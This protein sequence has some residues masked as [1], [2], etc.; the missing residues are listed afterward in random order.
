MGLKG[1]LGSE[2]AGTLK[3][4]LNR[5]CTQQKLQTDEGKDFPNC[6]LN[7]LLSSVMFPILLLIAK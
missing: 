3:T 7:K 2:I 4:T 1:K 5:E 6:L